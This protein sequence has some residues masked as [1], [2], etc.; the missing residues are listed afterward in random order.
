MSPSTHLP[1]ADALGRLPQRP[2][3]RG[4]APMHARLEVSGRSTRRSSGESLGG[5]EAHSP[6][7]TGIVNMNVEPIPA[8]LV[9]PI[10]PP[11]SSTDL[12]QSGS[13]SP[14]PLLSC[15]SR[16]LAG[17]PRRPRADARGA[18]PMPVSVTANGL[19][20]LSVQGL[21]VAF[22]SLGTG[23]WFRPLGTTFSQG[24][25]TWRYRSWSGS[26]KT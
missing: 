3:E 22:E 10:R 23:N 7:R 2:G 21:K 6:R 12:R 19:L 16:P 18:M 25:C 20:S 26:S 15:P 4:P 1:S 5:P 9:T 8:R 24:C 14:V 17:I 11:W 13:P